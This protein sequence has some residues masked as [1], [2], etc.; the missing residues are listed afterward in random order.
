MLTVPQAAG[1]QSRVL[2]PGLR[3]KFLIKDKIGSSSE[4]VLQEKPLHISLTHH[5]PRESPDSVPQQSHAHPLSAPDTVECVNEALS[6]SASIYPP[7][8]FLSISLHLR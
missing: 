3:E 6:L 5:N 4:G 7:L 1:L 8:P 2:R